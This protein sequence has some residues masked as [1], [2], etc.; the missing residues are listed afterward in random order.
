[1]METINIEVNRPY[2]VIIGRQILSNASKHL[3]KFINNRKVL[4][5]TDTNIESNQ[6]LSQLID[7]IDT[8][9]VQLE[10]LVIPPGE[11][12]KNFENVQKIID[13][14]A[15]NHFSRDDLLIALGGGVIGDL[16]GFTASIY[17]RG[18][19]YVQIPTTFLSAID[20][21][22]GGKTAIDITHGKNMVGAF[23][24][25]LV[26]LCDVDSFKTLPQHI[27]EDGCSELI[28]YAMIMNSDLLSI[29]IN[30]E[31]AINPTDSDIISIVSSCVQMKK[32]VVL[33]DEFDQGLRQLLNFGHT[34]GHAI[35]QLSGYSISHGRSVALG[36]LL[37]TKMAYTQGVLESDLTNL[38]KELLMKYHL[39]ADEI[40]F[41][42][43]QLLTTMLND[44]KRRGDNITLILPKKFGQCKL[45]DLSINTFKDWFTEEW[46]AYEIR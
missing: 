34:L 40:N 18:I 14:L 25:P 5:V 43:D 45:I 15:I 26:V 6:Y 19:D 46:Q 23:H 22:V 21:S 35:E 42:S 28:K 29:L 3:S 37:F 41:N 33:N 8:I 7:N 44:K 4:I 13:K 27:F 24:H 36:M 10:S 32:E 2:Q 9:P 11:S 20:S 39:L 16:V 1:M 12:Q 30:K 31:E 17:L 38:L